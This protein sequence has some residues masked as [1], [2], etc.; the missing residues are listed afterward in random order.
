MFLGDMFD[1]PGTTTSLKPMEGSHHASCMSSDSLENMLSQQPVSP[2]ADLSSYPTPQPPPSLPPTTSDERT[3]VVVVLK[4]KETMNVRLLACL[5][6]CLPAHLPAPAL[7]ACPPPCSCPP[8][9]PSL[10]P[11]SSLPL[12]RA[13]WHALEGALQWDEEGR[14]AG[15]H[16]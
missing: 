2:F 8:C 6:A 16:S 12:P 4:E 13:L 7:S 3:S 5:P 11:L 9:L 15:A 1:L 14:W 10:S